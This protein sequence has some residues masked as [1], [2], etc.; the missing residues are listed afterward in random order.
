LQNI[1]S[2]VKLRALYDNNISF[3]I[4]LT[5]G[6]IEPKRRF[7]PGSNE[8]G[9]IFLATTVGT[10]QSS[11]DKTTLDSRL[12]HFFPDPGDVPKLRNKE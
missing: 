9:L 7:K 10:V 5:A 2:E 11:F 4:K 1:F 8:G 6:A 12:S 3:T